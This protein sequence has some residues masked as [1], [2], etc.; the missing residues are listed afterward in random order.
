M[1]DPIAKK[2]K[3][4]KDLCK[5]GREANRL[6]YKKIRSR[7]KKVVASAMRLRKKQRI[8]KKS[9]TLCSSW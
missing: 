5:D 9:R 2:K 4:F 8:C 6:L 3:A 7:T 1:K